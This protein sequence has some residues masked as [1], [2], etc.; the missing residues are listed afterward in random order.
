MLK[1]P[2][3]EYVDDWMTGESAVELCKFFRDEAEF[4]GEDYEI[5]EVLQEQLES[6]LDFGA[7]PLISIPFIEDRLAEYQRARKNNH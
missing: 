6:S 1:L 7:S 2:N 4:D 3:V 5:W